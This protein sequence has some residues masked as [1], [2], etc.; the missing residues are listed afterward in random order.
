MTDPRRDLLRKY[1][2]PKQYRGQHKGQRKRTFPISYSTPEGTRQMNVSYV[3]EES[4]DVLGTLDGLC[5]KMNRSR[6][7]VTRLCVCW[8][9][10]STAA[11]MADGFE[12]AVPALADYLNTTKSGAVVAAVLA[13][14]EYTDAQDH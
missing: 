8:A 13:Y 14:K 5:K 2:P 11:T 3:P 1:A 12:D 9:D 7:E 6:S 4:G 10:L